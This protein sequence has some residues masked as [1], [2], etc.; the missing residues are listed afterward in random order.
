M[1]HTL[2]SSQEIVKIAS[3]QLANNRQNN[4]PDMKQLECYEIDSSF[5]IKAYNEKYFRPSKLDA[6]NTVDFNTFILENQSNDPEEITLPKALTD[7]PSDTIINFFS[8]L[9]EA[10][11]GATMKVGCGT[12]GLEALPYPFS[13]A[14]LS[15]TLKKQLPYTSFLKL[16]E[17]INHIN[18]IKMV[19]LPSMQTIETSY[20][21]LIEFETIEGECFCYYYGYLEVIFEND[22]YLINSLSFDKEDFFCAPY[23]GWQHNAELTVEIMYHNWCNLIL[24][25]YP[26]QQ[27]DYIKRIVI[28]GSDGNQYM[29][30]FCTLTNGTDIEIGQYKKE[31]ND[32]VKVAMTPSKCL[33]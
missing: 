30:V 31:T 9:R 2:Y 10:N 5:A 27:E 12:V 24:K 26:T 14:F 17:N 8:M 7:T 19:Y 4:L 16:F 18:L 33:G 28:D 6:I 25:Q 13:Y 23:H 29:F 1:Q 11:Q 20:L 15:S 32:W 21:F 3:T 22:S